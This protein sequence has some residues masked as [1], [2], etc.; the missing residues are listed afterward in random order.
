MKVFKKVFLMFFSLLIFHLGF[1]SILFAE[2]IN[3]N[4]KKLV[5]VENIFYDENGKFANGW[6]D[7]G[8]EWYF[9][10]DGKKHTGFATDGNGK[11]YFKNGKYGTAYVDKIFYEEGKTANGWYDDG[12]D[13]YFFKNGKKHTGF[14]TDGNGKMYFKDG[15]Y[16][17][18]YVDKVFYG[19]GKPADWWYDDGTGWYFFQKGEKFTGIAKDTSGYKYFINGKYGSGIYNDILYKDG[20]KSEGKVYVNGIF[21]GEDLKPANWWYDDGTGWYFFQKGKKHTGFATDGNGKM[22]FKDGKYGKGYVDKVFYGEGKPAD[23][24]YDDGT[25]WY[26]FQKG[27]KFTGIAKDASGEKYFV[28]G[29]YG[30]GIYNDILYKDGVKSE[31]KVY[32][33]GIF[34]GE[35]LKPANWWYDDGTAWYFFQNG[36]K[37]T[38]F[39]KD[40][41][42]EKYFVDGKYANGLYNEKLYKDGIETEGEVYINGLFFDKDKKLANGWYYDGIEELYFE[43]GSKYTG[44]LEGKF[45]VDGK[46]ANKYYD[47]KYY[48]DGEE[49]EIP[50]SMLIE[51]GIKAYN[52]DDDKY[53]TGCWLY[54]AA[55]GLYSKGVSITPPELLKL[56]PN[57]GDPR[58]GVMGN[59]KEHLY[60]GVFPACY[61]SALVPV[62]KKF[63]PTIEDFSGASFEDIKL[64]LSQGHTVQIWLSRVIPSNIINVGDGETIIASAWYHSVL[65]IG[66]N[67]KGFYHIE[68]VNQNK[69]VF[70]D[71][72]KSLSQY[73]VFGRKAI[74]YK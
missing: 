67:D 32:V 49:I 60:Q 7:D 6:Y 47:G 34:Y 52:F 46:Y 53:Y 30:I 68:A 28:D 69:K 21:Y 66:Y 42:G 9:F 24:W 17:K 62:L 4:E 27:E 5:Y 57:T 3:E 65:L 71:F 64:Q 55:S 74:L 63:V 50:D 54:S 14:A 2:N 56:L 70:L 29:K 38:G 26:F 48:K 39:A 15:K 25:A 1:N 41:S 43:N 61:P 37:H 22:Y 12:S 45:L 31:G 18:G 8:T 19:E 36:K 20:I 33:D 35:D 16:G 40:A 13:W 23:W 58:T 59:P 73:E 10:K 51:E 44:V 72:E 11:M